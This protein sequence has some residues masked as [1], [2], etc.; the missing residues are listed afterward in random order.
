MRKSWL[1]WKRWFCPANPMQLLHLMVFIS[2][3][4]GATWYLT[5]FLQRGWRSQ[6]AWVIHCRG[7]DSWKHV[8][9]TWVWKNTVRANKQKKHLTRS[10][11]AALVTSWDID[12]TTTSLQSSGL[13]IAVSCTQVR[14]IYTIWT[15]KQWALAL[16]ILAILCTHFAG[17][18]M[19]MA[20]CNCTILQISLFCLLVLSAK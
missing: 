5:C 7:E 8:K 10:T 3:A 16:H 13:I 4:K 14:F 1:H 6:R 19:T 18:Q 11:Q 17:K 20:T 9:C 12:P 15:H 2:F